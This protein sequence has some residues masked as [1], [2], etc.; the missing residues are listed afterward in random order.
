VVLL[1]LGVL[2]GFPLLGYWLDPS[3]V[4]RARS[5]LWV[6]LPGLWG[7]SAFVP[8]DQ[9]LLQAGRPAQQSLLMTINVSINAALNLAL[10][11]RY[12]LGG[13]ALATALA[14]ASSAATLTVAVWRALGGGGAAWR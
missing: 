2:Y 8:S 6:L 14:Y 10:I 1:S 13:A 3:L 4:A 7:Y 5:L 12:G 9:I 11:R